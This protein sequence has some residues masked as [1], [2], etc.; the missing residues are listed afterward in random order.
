MQGRVRSP[1]R[2]L[3]RIY[4]YPRIHALPVAA[5]ASTPLAISCTTAAPRDGGLSPGYSARAGQGARLQER[6]Q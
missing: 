1:G 4:A 2:P 6:R 5:V 3:A